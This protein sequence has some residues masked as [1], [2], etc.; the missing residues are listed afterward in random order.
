MD[1][2]QQ[3][4]ESMP[5][6]KAVA[7]LALPTILGQLIT[8]IY[9]LADTLYI[10]QTGNPY[11]VA[12]ISVSFVLFF[13][14]NALS[15]LFGIGGGSLISR[16]LGAKQPDK[17]KN[18]CAFSFWA[19]IG[20]AIIY[21]LLV[22]IFMDPLLRLLGA[23]D[24]TIGYARDYTTWVIVIGGL[25]N[26]INMLMGNFLRSVG[27]AKEA[28]MGIAGGG[29][30][31]IILDPIFIFLLHM[32]VKGAAMATML[33]N[34]CAAI[35]FLIVFLRMRRRTSLSISPKN[36][37]LPWTYIK[38]ILAVGFPASIA[39]ILAS[40]SNSVINKLTSAYGDIPI[41]AIGIVKK[42]DIIPMGIGMGLS[43]GMLPLVAYNYSA[44]NY[45]RM[46]AISRFG[47]WSSVFFSIFC[48]VIFQF[49]A[50]SL[51]R[52]FINDAETIEIGSRFLRIVCLS[53]PVMQMNFLTNTTFQAM[54]KGWQSLV[55]SACRQGLIN[56]PLLFLMDHILGLFGIVWTQ[57][58][59][60]SLTLALSM[61]L[62]SSI[63]KHLHEEEEQQLSLCQK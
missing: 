36:V 4:F 29:I 43:Q 60:D 50:T 44:K 47:R 40:V 63:L 6:P 25:P 42:I 28:S 23:S 53:V 32:A 34:S 13:M 59:A 22:L 45:E 10:G 26:I 39:T 16:L 19:G 49:F 15:N 51:L 54:G 27:Y 18:V 57:L 31:N 8:I 56:I 11:M 41:A 38:Q 30:M 24:H 20:V 46:K 1:N 5:V 62:Y 17:A 48:V 9:N 61:G 12:A 33:A 58:I 52:L 2:K 7:S 55:L 21:I 37:Q 35:Y 14:L 3:I